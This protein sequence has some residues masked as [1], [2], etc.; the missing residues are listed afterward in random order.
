MVLGS[1]EVRS[2]VICTVLATSA[3]LSVN[4][5][6][7]VSILQPSLQWHVLTPGD[8][9]NSGHVVLWLVWVTQNS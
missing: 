1:P 8:S 6:L 5:Y 2:A 7:C 9:Q 4:L 3:P